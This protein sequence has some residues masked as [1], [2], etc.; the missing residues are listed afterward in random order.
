MREGAS[1]LN[2]DWFCIAVKDLNT[3][4]DVIVSFPIAGYWAA[5]SPKSLTD[6]EKE[7]MTLEEYLRRTYNKSTELKRAK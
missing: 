4:E 2:G 7:M 6:L 5:P 3:G 1:F